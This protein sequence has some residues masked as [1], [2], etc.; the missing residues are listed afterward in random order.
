MKKNILIVIFVLMTGLSCFAQERFFLPESK[1]SQNTQ[2]AREVKNEKEAVKNSGYLDSLNTYLALRREDS[3]VCNTRDCQDSIQNLLPFRYMAEGRCQEIK[4]K[5]QKELCFALQKRD[6]ASL[7]NPLND[8]CKGLVDKNIDLL[9]RIS[10][11]RDFSQVAGG[12]MSSD[13]I[14]EITAVYYGFENYSIIACERFLQKENLPLS[15]KLSCS[16]MFSEKPRQKIDDVIDDLAFFNLSRKKNDLDFCD[17][18]DNY[19]I[20]NK[21]QTE[22]DKD[23]SEIW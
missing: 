20:K 12:V 19:L 9:N 17:L 13:D 11:G 14:M 2:L 22:I 7:S 3:S 21:C 8:F 5:A 10:N 1:S 16:I 23:L 18:I 6:C 15:L 4:D